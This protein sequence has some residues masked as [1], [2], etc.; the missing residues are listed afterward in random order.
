M[1]FIG[2]I[3]RGVGKGV[4]A[5]A[6]GV[7]NRK[8]VKAGGTP[9]LSKRQEKKQAKAG[10]GTLSKGI[11][12][13]KQARIDKRAGKKEEKLKSGGGFLR[14]AI[15]QRKQKKTAGLLP[16]QLRKKNKGAG[17]GAGA[18]LPEFSDNKFSGG[19]SGGTGDMFTGGEQEQDTLPENKNNILDWIK[20]NWI[21]LALV[22][23]GLW[24]LSKLLKSKKK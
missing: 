20:G 22:G 12:A 19:G 21:I 13:N 17:A 16:R 8:I 24:L 18:S 23:G 3:V 11:T 2:G 7:K 4:G 15:T 5:L 9:I 10:A 14:R 6:R 1:G